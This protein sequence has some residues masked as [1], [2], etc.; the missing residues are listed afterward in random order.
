MG[1]VGMNFFPL[2]GQGMQNNQR[3]LSKE[4]HTSISKSELAGYR[5]VLCI[6]ST[7]R[8]SFLAKASQKEH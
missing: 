4:C 6:P 8:A 1:Q 3:L 7:Q 2:K 5:G